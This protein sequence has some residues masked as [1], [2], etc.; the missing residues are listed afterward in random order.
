[1]VATKSSVGASRGTGS[2]GTRSEWIT[3]GVSR[4]RPSG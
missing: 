1:M 3:A 4:E 2:A